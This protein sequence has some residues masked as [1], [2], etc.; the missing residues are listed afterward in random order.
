VLCRG[1][2][3]GT[4]P[5]SAAAMKPAGALQDQVDVGDAC[6][7]PI[8]RLNVSQKAA[9]GWGTLTKRQPETDLPAAGAAATSVESRS[10]RI[11]AVRVTVD[12]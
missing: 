6:L 1:L 3:D 9:G 5:G 2:A 10:A 8:G 12:P 7:V 4:R 11:V